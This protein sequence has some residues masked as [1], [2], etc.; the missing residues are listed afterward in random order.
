MKAM[1]EGWVN[2]EYGRVSFI[3]QETRKKGKGLRAR[4]PFL[5]TIV[6]N[7]GKSP[8]LLHAQ[9]YRPCPSPAL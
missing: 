3:S 7:I 4:K 2:A 5:I 8:E 1:K 9:K 6:V